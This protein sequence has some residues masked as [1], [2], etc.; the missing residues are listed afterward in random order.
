MTDSVMGSIIKKSVTS[1]KPVQQAAGEQ[2]TQQ[3]T[4]SPYYKPKTTTTISS[5]PSAA[6]IL[7]S[8][9]G[10]SPAPSPSSD[11]SP[12]EKLLYP[13]FTSQVEQVAGSPL[14]STPYSGST[15]YNP[16]GS[17]W[18]TIIS[19]AVTSGMPFEQ[20]VGQQLTPI[21]EQMIL[22]GAKSSYVQPTEYYEKW[23][24]KPTDYDYF[25]QQSKLQSD[26]FFGTG[27][28]KKEYSFMLSYPSIKKEFMAQKLLYEQ[29]TS[30]IK[31]SKPGSQWW[32]D[33]NQ[34][35]VMEESE[36]F[37]SKDVLGLM[38]KD[39][40]SYAK[41][42][43]DVTSSFEAVKVNIPR[44]RSSIVKQVGFGNLLSAYEGAGYTL[45]VTDKGMFFGVPKAS[46]VN[47]AL[48]GSGSANA[49]LTNIVSKVARLPI[50]LDPTAVRLTGVALTE[51]GI[52]TLFAIGASL[53]TGN[54]GY[55]EAEYERLSETSLGLTK[56]KSED[57]LGYT[58]RFWTSPTAITSVYIPLLTMGAGYVLKGLTSASVTGKSLLALKLSQVGATGVGKGIVAGS[59]IVGT[60]LLLAGIWTTGVGIAQTAAMAPER[61]PSV[62]GS[63]VWAWGSAIGGYKAGEALFASNIPAPVFSS[64]G[65]PVYDINVL[66]SVGVAEKIPGVEGDVYRFSYGR[67]LEVVPRGG[68]GGQ[69]F[70]SEMTGYGYRVG[71][72][73]DVAYARGLIEGEPTGFFTKVTR[74]DF[75]DIKGGSVKLRGNEVVDFSV[76]GSFADVG[77][78]SVKE[79]GY[80][81]SWRNVFKAQLP[82]DVVTTT[83]GMLGGVDVSFK[84]RFSSGD[85]LFSKGKVGGVDVASTIRSSKLYSYDVSSFEHTGGYKAG[86]VLQGGYLEKGNVFLVN[87]PIMDLVG[88]KQI[89]SKGLKGFDYTKPVDIGF[90]EKQI[91]L[92]GA[93]PAGSSKIVKTEFKNIV[94]GSEKWVDTGFDT[95]YMTTRVS[96]KYLRF[97][98]EGVGVE[99]KHW[100][101][102]SPRLNIPSMGG[103]V[104]QVFSPTSVGV[105]LFFGGLI[106]PKSVG[107]L[108]SGGV[109]VG[110]NKN[111]KPSIINVSSMVSGLK[112]VSML[113]MGSILRNVGVSGLAN[114]SVLKPGLTSGLKSVSELGLV[115]VSVLKNV[116]VL[117]TVS[118]LKPAMVTSLK[119]VSVLETM[120]V[121]ELVTPAIVTTV[122][123]IFVP[124]LL[125]KVGVPGG[126][127]GGGTRHGKKKGAR[128]RV[129]P[130]KLYT[131]IF[132]G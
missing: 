107:I 74:T 54:K 128:K 48:Y 65:K 5:S 120:V 96:G 78:V 59:K 31:A 26:I 102:V 115:D 82:T 99:S 69:K 83:K 37:E 85:I 19:K 110:L 6:S 40:S 68:V 28:L 123:P 27:E 119:Q 105:D 8:I 104:A 58:G 16:S 97:I 126:G 72:N 20:A 38:E 127:G 42:F 23:G 122:P 90:I 91:D 94:G 108:R 70:Y 121:P 114:V 89:V 10:S 39:W 88:P 60:G 3:V 95:S 1:G 30:M 118:L 46:D 9:A 132:G 24:Y 71:E 101:D 125:P 66:K 44:L 64:G 41:S 103:V 52:P 29:T 47:K 32:Y 14:A 50:G 73:I 61:L 93:G 109:S 33:V 79:F 62:L 98:E 17:V 63:S 57:V 124:P 112:T 131:D 130:I 53:I 55:S 18:N 21:H 36:Y 12:L 117:N 116:S 111:L 22:S 75:F 45:D 81:S 113:D 4:S 34:N 87:E 49:L 15:P 2:I 56:T 51:G 7:N 11:F 80:T 86:D 100:V 84:T 76:S 35:L 13:S 67:E 25:L 106:S 92:W 43:E 129:H 77:A